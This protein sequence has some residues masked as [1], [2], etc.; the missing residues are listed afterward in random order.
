MA[1]PPINFALQITDKNGRPT[2]QFIQWWQQ[3]RDVNDTIPELSTPAQVS[4]VIDVL[5]STRGSLLYR[6]SGGWTLLHPG[7][8]GQLLKTQGA[9][10]DPT[11]DDVAAVLDAISGTQG[12]VLYRGATEWAALAPGTPGEVLTTQGAG[13]N[14]AWTASA[15]GDIT[16]TEE[17]S[18]FSVTNTMLGGG[19]YIE[20]NFSSPSDITVPS[21]LTGSEPARFESTGSG[22]VTFLESGTTINSKDGNL[23]IDGQYGV[24]TLVPKGSDVYTLWGDLAAKTVYVQKLYDTNGTSRFGIANSGNNTFSPT[25]TIFEFSC[26]VNLQSTGSL[27]WIWSFGNDTQITVDAAGHISFRVESD[28]SVVIF[29]GAT[30]ESLTAGTLQHIYF[31]YDCSDASYE[32]RIDGTEVNYGALSIYDGPSTATYIDFVGVQYIL[33]G[34][35]INNA[36]IIFGD[37]WVADYENGY[38]AF[39]DGSGNPTDLSSLTTPPIWLGGALTA[40]DINGGAQNGDAVITVTAGDLTDA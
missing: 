16:I 36:D 1:T 3:Q 21:G 11:W 9:S 25:S 26:W 12:T 18:A 29:R 14:P 24:V 7:T 38:V 28:T 37:M 20:C 32:I 27:H 8:A 4:S 39:H 34:N 15:S 10:A 40:A 33:S 31:R 2:P 30:S 23:T 5:G 6:G 19:Q 22:E 35:G 17:T 13:S